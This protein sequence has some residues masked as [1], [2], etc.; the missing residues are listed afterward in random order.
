MG[1]L[2]RLGRVWL[3]A[4]QVLV[5]PVR[6]EELRQPRQIDLLGVSRRAVDPD[7][8]SRIPARLSPP[9]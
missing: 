4:Q 6:R 8:T 9:R 7:V 1:D 2:E 3:V 5:L